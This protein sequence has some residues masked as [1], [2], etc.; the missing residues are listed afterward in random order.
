MAEENHSEPS[1][2]DRSQFYDLFKEI[3]NQIKDKVITRYL[4]LIEH[5]AKE[6]TELKKENIL[7]KNQLTYILKRILLNKND[8]T[9]AAR[10]N[11]LNN[12]NSSINYNRSMLLKDNNRKSNSM[13][14]PLKSCENYRIITENVPS[15]Y[16]E[17]N[18]NI[19]NINGTDNNVDNR[20]SGYLNSLY[21][22]NFKTTNKTG[23]NTFLNK[24]QTLI[25]ELFPNKNSSFYMN[26]EIEQ[27]NGNEGGKKI[28]KKRENN[29]TEKRSSYKKN[30]AR[31][32]GI[33][34]NST[35]KRYKSKYL[36]YNSTKKRNKDNSY[37]DNKEKN[38]YNTITNDTRK[39]KAK[40]PVIYS[41]RS[42][43][44]ANKF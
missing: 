30:N 37:L 11:K 39:N 18:N 21:R 33:K 19:L 32:N 14:R 34:N 22:N 4:Y 3:Q 41:K 43:F 13:L 35:G 31:N 9:S 8:Y 15:R 23:G 1:G 10:T 2:I 5:Q 25:D 40:K 24:N 27:I 44:L 7:L 20:V 42:P 28:N 16:K 26:T 29:S 36:E 17:N 12:L 6:N 38:N